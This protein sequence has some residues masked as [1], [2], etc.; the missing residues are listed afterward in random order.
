ML[1]WDTVDR[2]ATLHLKGGNG[3]L[4]KDEIVSNYVTDSPPHIML[5]NAVDFI[6]ELQIFKDPLPSSNTA[7]SSSNRLV[8]PL[9]TN[10]S[11]PDSSDII[12]DVT[13]TSLKKP[14]S[15]IDEVAGLKKLSSSLDEVTGHKQNLP[16]V[17]HV[18]HIFD[19][20]LT[21]IESSDNGE[22]GTVPVVSPILDD[23]DNDGD[24]FSFVESMMDVLDEATDD[25]Y[26]FLASLDSGV[27]GVTLDEGPVE[28][29]DIGSEFA[30][31]IWDT[32]PDADCIATYIHESDI[33]E[34]P[35]ETPTDE[36][37]DAISRRD[38]PIVS[39]HMDAYSILAVLT[40]PSIDGRAY[41]L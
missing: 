18:A 16:R 9:S 20:S 3:L 13:M 34:V 35:L 32:I 25:I 41:H 27:M 38:D 1:Y 24:I 14:S 17:H 36:V 2:E 39:K 26:T 7:I 31:S 4:K 19:D 10:L 23:V 30:Q 40:C 33:E 5:P 37:A 6:D 21:P 15:S 8:I 12:A 22:I 28:L 29:K 11:D